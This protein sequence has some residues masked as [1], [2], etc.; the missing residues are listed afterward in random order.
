MI[1]YVTRKRILSKESIADEQK[2]IDMLNKAVGHV[3]LTK[4]EEFTL[5][6]LAGWE[7]STIRDI[8]NVFQRA[9]KEQPKSFNELT[10]EQQAMWWEQQRREHE[11]DERW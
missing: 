10:L 6:W 3:Q 9:A 2:H 8:I 4:S 5:Q 1:K 7:T 11:D